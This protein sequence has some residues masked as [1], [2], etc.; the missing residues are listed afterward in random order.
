MLE[1]MLNRIGLSD[2]FLYNLLKHKKTPFREMSAGTW[3]VN[4]SLHIIL[5]P[6]LLIVAAVASFAASC[7]KKSGTMEVV[8]RIKP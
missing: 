5:C 7:V 2:N 6:F 3:F 4:I 1:T 8:C